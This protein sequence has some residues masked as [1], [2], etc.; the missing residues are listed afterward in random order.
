MSNLYN[1]IVY[2]ILKYIPQAYGVCMRILPLNQCATDNIQFKRKPTQ[3]EFRFYTS[4]INEGLKVLDKEVGLIIH[5]SSVP[6]KAGLN[7]GIGSLLSKISELVF[8]PFIRSH[9]L[10]KIMQDPIFIRKK[11]KDEPFSPYDPVSTS[12]NI[13]MIPL[14]KLA[15]DEYAN[16]LSQKTLNYI[17]ANNAAEQ[18]SDKVNY[19]SVSLNYDKAL[20]EVYSNFVTRTYSGVIN[21]YTPKVDLEKTKFLEDEYYVFKEKHYD[22]LAPNAIYEILAEKNGEYDW[23]KWDDIEKGL[24]VDPRYIEYKKSMLEDYC[25]KIDF[26]IFKQWLLEREIKKSNKSDLDLGI[27]VI[28]DTPIAFT[29]SEVWQNQDIFLK[30]L[31]LGCPP[32]FYCKDGHPWGFAVLDPAKIFNKDGTLGKGGDFLK[33]RYEAIFETSPG[34]VR[35]DHLIGLIDPYVYQKDATKMTDENSGRLHSSPHRP[36]L[37]KYSKF[38]DSDFTNIFEKIIFPAAA[39]YGVSKSDIICEDLGELTPPARMV[40]EKLGL[41][42]M[43]VVQYGYSGADAPARN[44]IMLGSHDNKSYIEFTKDLYEGAKILGWRRDHFMH[45]T[46]ILGSDT[47]V[48]GEDVQQHREYIRRKETNF[49]AASFAELFTSKA[50]KVQ[51]FFTDFF[52]IGKTY[53]VP[54]GKQGCWELRLPENWE[55]L[56]YDNLKKGLAINLPEAIARAIRQKGVDFSGQH[57]NLLRKLDYFT[58]I[59]K[60]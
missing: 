24:F 52:G 54:G 35:I 12:K 16:L 42:G 30:D 53:N 3:K 32:D 56:Y 41:T 5:N 39:K 37:S 49:L 22:E 11:L 47:A 18:S 27:S 10:S 36:F 44:V 57:K 58:R 40:I 13:Y 6:S 45:K 17:I 15:S 43:S 46:H 55:S 23:Q 2:D 21:D 28:A 1:Y 34:G 31:R 29:P 38:K 25:E 7:L 48:P 33:K 14:E 19:Q 4:A 8:K 26:H 59:L 9:G 60:E 51:I 50:K 20:K